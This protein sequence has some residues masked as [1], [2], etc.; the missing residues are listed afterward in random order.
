[1]KVVIE[2]L[3]KRSHLPTPGYVWRAAKAAGWSAA[4]EQAA[5]ICLSRVSTCLKETTDSYRYVE[6][7]E[8]RRGPQPEAG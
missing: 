2:R 5:R 7:G 4:P 3:I 1:M 6:P 8:G